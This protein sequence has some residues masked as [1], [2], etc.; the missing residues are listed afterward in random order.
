MTTRLELVRISHRSWCHLDPDEFTTDP[1]DK[2]QSDAQ[3]LSFGRRTRAASIKKPRLWEYSR[4]VSLKRGSSASALVTT[5]VRLSGMRMGKTP[6]N[7]R[8]AASSPSMTSSVR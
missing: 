5:G 7:V 2:E 6:L 4:N 1:T 3:A 8:H